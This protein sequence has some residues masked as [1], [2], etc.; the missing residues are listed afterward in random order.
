MT[1]RPVRMA[2]EHRQM[3]AVLSAAKVEYVLVGGVAMQI[4]GVLEPTRDL[5]IVIAPSSEN[6]ERLTDALGRL[7][8]SPLAVTQ[9]G[10]SFATAMGRLE[11]LRDTSGVGG[12]SGWAPRAQPIELEPGLTVDVADPADIE[13]N[14]L[15]ADRPKDHRHVELLRRALSPTPASGDEQRPAIHRLLG[16]APIDAKER[17]TWDAVARIAEKFRAT[18]GLGEDG[19]PLGPVLDGPAGDERDRILRLAERLAP[20]AVR[21]LDAAT[22]DRPPED[23]APDI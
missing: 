20:D 2:A 23:R 17:R 1:S 15:T 6:D 3:L 22:V 8:A 21:E 19:H 5:D 14:K 12:Y 16:E 7:R 9:T 18:H 11:I 10:T 4:Y 13:H